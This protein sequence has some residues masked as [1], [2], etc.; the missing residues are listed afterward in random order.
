[1]ER[2]AAGCYGPAAL[3]TLDPIRCT[4]LAAALAL[5][6]CAGNQAT[7]EGGVYRSA[8]A[9]FQLGQPG[10]GWERIHVE[11]SSDLALHNE[12]EGAI[13]EVNVSCD[14]SL[15]IPLAALTNHLLVGFRNR[16]DVEPQE[17]VAM[18]GREALR[19][20]MRATLDGVERE[21]LFYVLA[22]D[23]CVYD[24]ALIG[25]PGAPF[26]RAKVDYDRMISGFHVEAP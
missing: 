19:T 17:Y 18:D 2:L 3:R 24:F 14:P 9:D 7:F 26:S 10:P 23:G 6:A 16:E 12:A 8:D 21:L 15:D 1:M 22:K 20:H 25:V 13:I 5:C 11:G 4:A